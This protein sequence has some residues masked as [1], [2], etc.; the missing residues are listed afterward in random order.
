M[1]SGP[2]AVDPRIEV[3]RRLE[4]IVP[5]QLPDRLEAARLGIEQDPRAQVT[6]LMGG[7]DDAY[8]PPQVSRDEPREGTGRTSPART[9]PV[10]EPGHSRPCESGT[11]P[12]SG[13]VAEWLKAAPC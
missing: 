4:I 2:S 1:A 11:L 9:V 13:E 6:E 12:P 5:E 3:G 8:S 10:P 7:E